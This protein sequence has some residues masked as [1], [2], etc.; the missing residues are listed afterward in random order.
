MTVVSF[1]CDRCGKPTEG[2]ITGLGTAGFYDVRPGMGWEKM[3]REGETFVCDSCVTASV[4][5]AARQRLILESHTD[6][7]VAFA[8]QGGRL[9]GPGDDGFE[10]AMRLGPADRRPK[11]QP[12]GGHFNG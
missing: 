4:E 3:A 10:A 2:L 11:P 5:Y 8:Y 7:P 9:I 12:D 1:N 6:N